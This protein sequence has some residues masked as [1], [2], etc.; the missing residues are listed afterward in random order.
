[1]K[2]FTIKEVRDYCIAAHESIGQKYGEFPYS[3]HLKQVVDNVSRFLHLLDNEDE[4]ELAIKGA[5]AHDL[6]EDVKAFSYNDNVKAIGQDVAEIS[7]LMETP[8]G[9]NR[10]ERHC[11]AYYIGMA[12]DKIVVLD[13][14]GDRIANLV[15]SIAT[16]LDKPKRGSL[17]HRYVSERGHFEKHMRSAW[18]QLEPAWQE[19]D[20]IYTEAEGYIAQWELVRAENE[21]AS[22]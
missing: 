3:Y 11:D 17:L 10:D 9:R 7:F 4:R 2:K 1:M 20:G 8:K 19:L 5:W 15:A 6:S 21:K 14:V 13:K 22:V 16:F 18:P 12:V